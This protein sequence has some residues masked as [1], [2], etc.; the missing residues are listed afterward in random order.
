VDV[1][2]M[3]NK[4]LDTYALMEIAQGNPKFATYITQDFTVT[5]LT[6]AEFYAVLLREHDEA[7]ADSWLKKLSGFSEPTDVETLIEA[8]KFRYEH[9]KKRISFFDAAG[10]MHSKRRG[11]VFVTGDK[12]F[13]KLSG[14]EYVK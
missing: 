6:L 1:A 12:E 11:Y 10:Y 3:K 2:A 9:R 7:T 13:E 4:C 5:E 14:V 8:V